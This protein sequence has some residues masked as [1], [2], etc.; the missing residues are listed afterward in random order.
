MKTQF[1]PPDDDDFLP[2][3]DMET[4]EQPVIDTQEDTPEDTPGNP[5]TSPQ[6][7]TYVESEK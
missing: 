1:K 3:L 4:G 5:P 7:E 6:P 2:D